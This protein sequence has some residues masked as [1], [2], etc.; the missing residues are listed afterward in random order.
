MACEVVEE[1]SLPN[2][3]TGAGGSEGQ[4]GLLTIPAPKPRDEGWSLIAQIISFK[5]V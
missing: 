5:G 4:E 2:E 3:R 1:T